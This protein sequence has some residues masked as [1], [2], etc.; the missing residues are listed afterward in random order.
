MD[1]VQINNAHRRFNRFVKITKPMLHKDFFRV[2]IK[3]F[4]L[5]SMILFLFTFL[6]GTLSQ[7]YGFEGWVGVALGLLAFMIPVGLFVLLLFKADTIVRWLRLG[8]GFDEERIVL[9]DL[10]SSSIIR[11]GSI[12]IGA[13][14]IIES[15]PALLSLSLYIFKSSLREQTDHSQ[16]YLS[17]GINFVKIVL[18]YLLIRNHDF[19]SKLLRTRQE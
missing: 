10:S 9:G 7:L 8:E 15:L 18:G 5:Y 6:P 3:L 14:L 19:V 2:I 12:L 17:W 11:L 13:F 16:Q 4:G 1:D